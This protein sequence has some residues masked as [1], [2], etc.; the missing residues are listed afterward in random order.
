MSNNTN[1]E[2]MTAHKA[3][4]EL[5]ITGDRIDN[6]IEETVFVIAN[7]HSNSKIHGV[8]IK[9][10]IKTMKAKHQSTKDLIKRRDA[11]KRA[12]I[13]SNAS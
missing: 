1:T 11:L 12:V 3:L 5:K 2:Q 10:F 7:R 9:E 8:E 6:A 13:S 4:S